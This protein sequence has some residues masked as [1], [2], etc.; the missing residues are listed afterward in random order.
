MGRLAS[1]NAGAALLLA[2]GSGCV[3]ADSTRN[4]VKKPDVTQ[5]GVLPPPQDLMKPASAL[6]PGGTVVPAGGAG[7]PAAT[8]PVPVP[9]VVA[10]A[11]P[12]S[13]LAKLVGR[14]ERKIPATEMAV[15]WRN[16][17]AFLPDPSRNGALGAGLAGQLFLFGGPKLEFA[18]ADGTLTVDLIDETPRPAGQ[19]GAKPERWQ[20]DK[21][22]L[23]NLKT[24]DETWG[25]SYVLFLPW[26]A[27]KPDITKVRIS[28]RYDPDN[29]HTLY[30]PASS[31]T[32]D[33]S[34]PLGAP[35]WDGT[36]PTG[37]AGNQPRYQSHAGMQPGGML[38]GAMLPGAM[39]PGVMPHNAAPL[40]I[41][42][43]P[44]PLGATPNPAPGPMVTGSMVTGPAP[45]GTPAPWSTPAPAMGTPAPWSTPAPV[46]A[47]PAMPVAPV[48]PAGGP[49]GA[50][51]AA[52]Y[53]PTGAVPLGVPNEPLM[54][55]MTTIDRR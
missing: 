9:G 30:S 43:T 3:T 33:T 7:A 52:P 36:G 44:I 28:V 4:A 55:I 26:P 14:T 21:N 53:G 37:G 29:G 32:I 40:S 24:V 16:R 45:M 50:M 23:R 18:Q 10:T 12:V 46:G 49:H 38:P 2:L 8:T 1:L 34:A 5:P 39:A 6:G 20:F 47:M 17:I 13:P 54:P 42:S 15:T 11:P 48:A 19:P 51:P 22:T 41:N 25:K 31:L 27:Y 35:V